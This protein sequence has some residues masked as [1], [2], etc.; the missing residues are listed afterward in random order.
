VSVAR[1]SFFATCAPGLEPLLMAEARALKLPK[2]EQ[3]TGG[4]YFEGSLADAARANLWLRTAVRVLLRLT[5]FQAAAA[6]ELFR[7]ASLIDWSRFLEPE[8]KLVVAAHSNESVLDHTLFVEQR[9]KDAICDQFREKTGKRPSVDKEA[10]DLGVHVHLF[11]DR[12]SL[13]VDTSGE[14][15]HKRGWRRYQGRAP[16]SETL[17]AAVVLDS[18]WDRRSPLV[19]PM[20]GSGTILVEAAWLALGIAPGSL[21]ER[22]AFER[23]KE[24][25]PAHSLKL[26]AQARGP[27][28]PAGK[29]IL[30][31]CDS[32][33]ATLAGAQQNLESAGVAE[34][35]E[36]ER[37]R[38]EALEYKRGW[39]AWIASNLPYG[40]RIGDERELEGLFARFG[41]RLKERCGG[42]HATLLSGNP[43]LT[44]ALGL[45]PQRTRTMQNGAIA[46]ELL[47]C[48]L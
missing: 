18:G 10:P 13:L 31:G 33:A 5:R 41:A 47:H 38:A 26:R 2:L 1:E 6:D 35:V 48:E 14:S 17:A 19:D 4:V 23:W 43:K 11:R 21:R 40:E 28:K 22:F 36:L 46:C 8:G 45:K 7:G 42:W 12:C 39:N 15:L 9:V 34:F 20:C 25:E 30:R 27:R 29:L 37:G 32:D 24:W 3:Q 44:Q 16:L